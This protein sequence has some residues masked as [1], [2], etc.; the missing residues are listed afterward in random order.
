MDDANL[1]VP[2]AE[3]AARFGYH[4]RRL[5]SGLRAVIFALQ[6]SNDTVGPHQLPPAMSSP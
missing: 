3:T 5:V 4:A 1:T 6:G 2:I